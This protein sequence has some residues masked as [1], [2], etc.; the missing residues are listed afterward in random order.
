MRTRQAPAKDVDEYITGF[1]PDV[2]EMLQQI[3]ATIRKAAPE[4]R[5][6][7][8][9]QIPAFTLNGNVVF[10]AGFKQHVSVY[11]APRGNKQ[12]REEL[13]A[14]KGGKG[15]VRFP[16]DKPIP[17]DLITRITKLRVQEDLERAKAK[18]K[19]AKRRSDR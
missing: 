5:E 2:Q 12:F 13:S 9:Y 3:R 11:P 4:L 14:Y 16:L 7:I 6:A 15:T 19:K 8:K 18:G 10:F 1:P 17:F